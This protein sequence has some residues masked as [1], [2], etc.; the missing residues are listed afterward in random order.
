MLG[1][2]TFGAFLIDCRNPAQPRHG[3]GETWMRRFA[4]ELVSQLPFLIAMLAISWWLFP[5]DVVGEALEELEFVES[6]LLTGS[7]IA[8]LASCLTAWV[9]ALESVPAD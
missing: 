9:V 5:D 6:L 4:L 1:K 3:H 8:F 7:F 2:S